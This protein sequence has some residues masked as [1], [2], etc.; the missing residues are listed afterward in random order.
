MRNAETRARIQR[1]TLRGLEMRRRKARV[2]PAELRELMRSGT[3][4]PSMLPFVREA[5]TEASRLTHALGGEAEISEQRAV[6]I[7]D[8]ARA[9]LVLRAVIAAF[10]QQPVADPELASKI[11]T[12]TGS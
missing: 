6:L 5:I 4:A 11:G 10:L 1:G 2:A 9:G 8:I 3:V 12:L 7:Q